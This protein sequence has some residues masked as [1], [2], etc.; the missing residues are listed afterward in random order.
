MDCMGS[1]RV[2]HKLSN[3]DLLNENG[4]RTSFKGMDLMSR[5]EKGL[6]GHP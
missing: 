4:D 6:A 5:A 3:F 2:R 1:Q